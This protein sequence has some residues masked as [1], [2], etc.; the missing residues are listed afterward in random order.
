MKRGQLVH[1]KWHDAEVTA[2]WKSADDLVDHSTTECE[3]VG[4]LVKKAT[5]RDPMYVV[6]S[7]R[8][9]DDDGDYEYNAITKIPK[10]WVD[11][12]EEIE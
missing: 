5:K 3:T 1:V 9:V 12:I 4:F 11:A 6:A 2:E 10:A 8:S 7:T